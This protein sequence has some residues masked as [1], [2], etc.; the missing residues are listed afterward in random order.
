ASGVN[1]TGAYTYDVC[2][3]VPFC[4]TVNSSDADNGQTVTMNWNNGIPGATFTTTAGPLPVG[5]FCWTPT[6]ADIGPNLFSVTVQD[7]ACPLVGQNNFGFAIQVTPPFTPANAGPD[8]SVCGAT[9]SLA[10]QL[11][12]PVQGT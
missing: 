10:G 9:A 2:A 12:W 1:G 3:G 5:T 7:N 6:T 11:P 4:F 8:Q